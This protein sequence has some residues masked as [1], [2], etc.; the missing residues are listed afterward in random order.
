MPISRSLQR[1]SKQVRSLWC[2]VWS[3]LSIDTSFLARIVVENWLLDRLLFWPLKVYFVRDVNF[4]NGF[5]SRR[6]VTQGSFNSV[7]WR[8]KVRSFQRCHSLRLNRPGSF[9]FGALKSTRKVAQFPGKTL[10]HLC[11][12][13][14]FSV[15]S[16][17]CV[18]CYGLTVCWRSARSEPNWRFS[19]FFSVFF[20]KR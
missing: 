1:F 7:F 5:S 10:Y 15:L 2:V 6:W 11:A 9:F 14:F 16:G 17:E 18:S 19:T 8:R 3:S 20:W 4:C 13:L 12:G